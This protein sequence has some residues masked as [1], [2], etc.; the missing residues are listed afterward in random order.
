[1]FALTGLISSYKSKWPFPWKIKLLVSPT[2]I[3]GFDGKIRVNIR[4]DDLIFLHYEAQKRNHLLYLS[5]QEEDY[6]FLLNRLPATAVWQTLKQ[7][8]DPSILDYAGSQQLANSHVKRAETAAKATTLPLITQPGR[9]WRGALASGAVFFLFLTVIAGREAL[10]LGVLF[11]SLVALLF[12]YV[13]SFLA[14]VTF[15]QETIQY[16]VW[17]R[18][19]Q[20]RWDEITEI[21]FDRQGNAIVFRGN[22]K[23]MVIPGFLMYSQT[24]SNALAV[25][26]DNQ[27]QKQQ[28]QTKESWKAPYRRQKNTQIKP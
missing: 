5:T 25:L 21:E 18:R 12:I 28:I 26:L 11:F 20:I 10:W 14:P 9:V 17:H 3:S 4:W 22:G 7:Q 15:N 8:A 24:Q 6:L 16:T 27:V 23:Q 2:T 13:L 1:M 19:F